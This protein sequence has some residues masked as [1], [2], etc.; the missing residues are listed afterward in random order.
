MRIGYL[1]QM[2]IADEGKQMLPDL[3][4]WKVE[5]ARRLGKA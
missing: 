3:L 4:F 1:A 2:V 5:F